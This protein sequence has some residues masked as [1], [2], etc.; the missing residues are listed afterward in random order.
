MLARQEFSK[1]FFGPAEIPADRLNILRRAF[2]AT[3]KD[4]KFLEEVAKARLVADGPLTGEELTK[5]VREVAATPIPVVKRV[6]KILADFN[7]GKK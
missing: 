3:M 2:D 5:M 4:P 6:E 1:P 7:A